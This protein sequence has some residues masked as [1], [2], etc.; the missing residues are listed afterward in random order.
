MYDAH[1]QEAAAAAQKQTEMYQE[2]LAYDQKCYEKI[3]EQTKAEREKHKLIP[4]PQP[5]TAKEDVD[6]YLE[7]FKMNMADRDIPKNI[8]AHHLIPLLNS[9]CRAAVAYLPLGAKYHYKT[10][11]ALLT[12]RPA[13][14]LDSSFWK[15]AS[16]KVRPSGPLW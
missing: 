16:N 7:L 9:N 1:V 4:K 15:E 14:I 11:T 5:M 3:L 13:G 8:W 2:K 12:N 6:D 10:V